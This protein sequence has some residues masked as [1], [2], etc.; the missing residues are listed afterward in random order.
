M[1]TRTH[2]SLNWDMQLADD[3]T[4]DTVTQCSHCGKQYRFTF[5]PDADESYEDFVEWAL[6]DAAS[7]HFD[8]IDQA[9]TEARS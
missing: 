3:G 5:G 6:D 7:D 4:M 1:T 9:A 8:E 2:P